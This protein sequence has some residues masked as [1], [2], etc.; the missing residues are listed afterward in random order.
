MQCQVAGLVMCFYFIEFSTDKT[1]S[2]VEITTS[3]F[4]VKWPYTH[5]MLPFD[6]RY[7]TASESKL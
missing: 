4:A 6:S 2:L 7:A 3:F 1:D 5:F